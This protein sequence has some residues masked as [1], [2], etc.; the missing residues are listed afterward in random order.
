MISQITFLLLLKLRLTN[1]MTLDELINNIT[2]TEGNTKRQAT[3]GSYR[4]QRLLVII[5]K[6]KDTVV[7]N[8]GT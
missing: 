4:R 2:N 6:D 7:R 3:W 5:I 1:T 8:S